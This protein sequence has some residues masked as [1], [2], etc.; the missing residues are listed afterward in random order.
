MHRRREKA[1][2]LQP[3]D[4]Y[5]VAVRQV[6]ASSSSLFRIVFLTILAGFSHSADVVSGAMPKMPPEMERVL[7][8]ARKRFIRKFGREPGPGDPLIFDEDAD[9]QQQT[10]QQSV[11]AAMLDA[12]LRSGTPP[13][14]IYAF[15]KTG[16][17]V[18]EEG[19]RKLSPAERREWDAAID[20]YYELEDS[21]RPRPQ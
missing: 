3:P 4:R 1:E 5:V 21:A 10:D 12:M 9:T 20:E 13:S 17:I 8:T 6:P 7:K 18:G 15:R 11:E 14:L 2:V 16:R 19:Y